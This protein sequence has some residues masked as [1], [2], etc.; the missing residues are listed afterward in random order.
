MLF[1]ANPIDAIHAAEVGFP[2][3]V[4]EREELKDRTYG[5]AEEIAANAPFSLRAM[6]EILHAIEAKGRLSEAELKWVQRLRDQ[7]FASE[8]YA[9][10]K[11]AFN[12]GR[13][14]QFQDR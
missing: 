10:G 6:K 14:P 3:Y 4:V 11:T 12:E 1:T 7:A 8:D 9:E 2:N 13:D 5:M